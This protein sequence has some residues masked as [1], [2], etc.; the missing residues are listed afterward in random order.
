M[1]TE[2]IYGAFISDL[3]AVPLLHSFYCGLEADGVLSCLVV[4]M[5][6]G[7]IVEVIYPNGLL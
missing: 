6:K 2:I 4:G 7:Q 5:K 3:C 1:I